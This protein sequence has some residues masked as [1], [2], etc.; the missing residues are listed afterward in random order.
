VNTIDSPL[1]RDMA[2]ELV[3]AVRPREVVLFGS[4]ARGQAAPG[5]DVD[6]LV[7]EN[8]PFGKNRSRR[9]ELRRIRRALSRFRV[10]KDI[11][12]YSRDEVERWRNACNHVIARAYREGTVLYGQ[13]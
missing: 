4:R 11:L 5:S 6:L 7:V 1:L 10:P 9:Q 13:D 2:D 8:E 12:V 3:R